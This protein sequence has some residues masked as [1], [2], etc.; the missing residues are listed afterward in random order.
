M[1]PKVRQGWRILS[2]N[3]VHNT[4]GWLCIIR[5]TTLGPMFWKA[6]HG[7]YSP[8]VVALFNKMM[9]A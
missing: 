3:S 9:V 1:G 4:F 2:A 8:S 6:C 5:R 7:R